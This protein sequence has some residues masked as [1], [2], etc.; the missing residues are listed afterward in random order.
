MRGERGGL[1]RHAVT[2]RS[3]WLA[4]AVFALALGV[5]GGVWLEHRADPFARL[6][7]ADAL[8]YHEWATRLAEQ[9]LAGEPVFHQAPLFPLL[10]G[11]VYRAAGEGSRAEA[12]ALLLVALNALA[13]ALVVPLGRLYLGS[14]AAG[15][16]GALVGLFHGPLVFY[17]LKLLPGPLALATQGAALLAL[18]LA[19]RRPNALA[20]AAAGAAG[21]LASL[22]R[23]EMLLFAPLAAWV[24]LRAG[25]DEA[26]SRNRA[27][28]RPRVRLSAL[29]AGWLCVTA[30]VTLHN[31]ARGDL[32]LVSS[33]FGENLWV[34]N[35]PG[36]SGG[37]T[38]L[39]PGAGDLFSQRLLAERIAEA[40]SGRELR[41]SEVSSWWARHT[42]AAIVERPEAWLA[43]LLRKA[44]RILHPGDPTDL[45]SFALER[46][47]WLRSLWLLPVTP[48]FVLLAGA[49]GL[50]LALRRQPGAAW[51]LAALSGLHLVV[52]LAFFADTRLRLPLLYALLPFS[53]F[54]IVALARAWREPRSRP[55]ATALALAALAALLAGQPAMKATPRDAVRAAAVLS[56]QD[57]LDR[58]LELLEPWLAEAEPDPFVLDQAGWI[59]HKAGRLEAAESLYSRALAIELGGGRSNLESRLAQVL[60]GLGRLEEAAR[61]HDSAVRRPWANAGDWYERGL[62]RSRHGDAAGAAA[63]LRRAVELDPG[64]VPARQALRRLGS[65]G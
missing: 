4:A 61:R 9:G 59:H 40:E 25:S 5:H 51:P 60:E 28:A 27:S 3:A 58:A 7:V 63:D 16:A 56:R 38:P 17:G 62:F 48:W 13:L 54:A 64:F 21:G 39:A 14:T 29:V 55:V 46:R 20:F 42:L 37:H 43:V 33:S 35:Q 11:I 52:L 31:L 12:G 24:A 49:S 44:G 30:P 53:G 10:L 15:L 65:A 45:Y 23:A 18:G 8:S 36:A 34:G 47:L 2:S 50:L 19:R 41:P 6:L 32:V 1:V 26:P 57:R 22:A